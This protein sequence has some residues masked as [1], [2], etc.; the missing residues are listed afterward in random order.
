M[1]KW[2]VVNAICALRGYKEIELLTPE[3]VIYESRI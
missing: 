2:R 3:E 1:V